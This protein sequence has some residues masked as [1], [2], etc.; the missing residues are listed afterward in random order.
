[1]KVLKREDAI[2]DNEM[3]QL[4]N[5]IEEEAISVYNN[6]AKIYPSL[7]DHYRD[8]LKKRLHAFLVK[9]ADKN[10]KEYRNKMTVC[11]G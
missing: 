4:Q 6:D 10:N 8:E 5:K 11:I 9:Q 1:M 3:Q 7:M 2:G